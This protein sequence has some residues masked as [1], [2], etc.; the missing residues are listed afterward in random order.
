LGKTVQTLALLQQQ[1][2]NH[3]GCTNLLIMPTSLIF[4]WEMEARKFTPG[5][6]ILNYT[7]IHREKDV[8]KFCDYDL[9]L[10]SYGTVRMDIEIL[11]QVFFHYVIL[12]ESQVIK[13]PDSIIA[14]SVT[15]LKSKHRLILTGTPI[16][17][18]T[19]DLWSQM[20]FVNPGLLGT[21]RFFKNEFLNPIEKKHDELKTKKLY[22]L[23]KPFVLRRQKS[24]VVKDL[25]DKIENIQYCSMTEEQEK[26]YEKVKSNY[27]NLILDSIEQKGVGA[28]QILLLQGLTRLRQIANHP[29]LAESEY[30]DGSGKMEDVVHM[31]DRALAEDHKILIFSQFVKHLHLYADYLKEKN[32]DFAY[33]DGSTKERQKEVDKF[34]QSEDKRIFLIS[35]KAGGLGLNLTAADYVFLLDPWWNPAIEAQA[36]DR[37]YRIGQKNNVF[38]Y[39]FITKNTVE[40]KILMLQQNKLRLAQE[41]ITTEESFVK[42]L[43]KEDIQSIFE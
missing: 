34:Q 3:V 2:E 20:S 19:L 35:L 42:N 17:N 23:I 13:N 1:K 25:P 37:A 32:I 43:S 33:L 40:E 12:D 30:V 15:E 31:L 7:G 26:E 24:Q 38:T 11:K 41:L 8:S 29:I 16:E 5:M 36:I 27:R 39:K 14:K 18:S 22:A 10:T 6:K 28:S 9:V 4:N 21:Q